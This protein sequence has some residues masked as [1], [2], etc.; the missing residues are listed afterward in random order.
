MIKRQP[1]LLPLAFVVLLNSSP[2]PADI[3]AE[4]S[5]EIDELLN[6]VQQSDCVFIRNGSEHDAGDAADHMRLKLKRGKKYVNSTEQFI[7]RLASESSW[8]GK[9]YTIRCPG[10]EEEL[11]G[12]WLHELLEAIRADNQAASNP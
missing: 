5:A 1:L 8:S 7:D 2:C 4:T 9:P 6:Q 11:T 10:H 12:Q 3:S